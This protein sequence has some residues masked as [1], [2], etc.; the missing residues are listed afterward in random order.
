MKPTMNQII[1]MKKISLE[2]FINI[3]NRVYCMTEVMDMIGYIKHRIDIFKCQF[4]H[5]KKY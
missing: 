3:R 2:F 4:K 5:V 1:A